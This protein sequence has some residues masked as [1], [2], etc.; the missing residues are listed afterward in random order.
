MRGKRVILL[1]AGRG[2]RWDNYLGIPKH[3]IEIDSGDGRAERLIDRTVRLVRERSDEATTILIASFDPRYEVPGTMRYEPAHGRERFTDTDKFLSSAELWS[4]DDP[5]IVL[6]GDVFFTEAAMETIL[7]FAGA[8]FAFFGRPRPS[9]CTGHL[10][11]EMFALVIPPGSREHLQRTMLEVRDMLDEGQIRRG[12]GWECYRHACG[13]TPVCVYAVRSDVANHFVEI[14]DFTDDFDS[15]YDYEQ[16]L[17]RYELYKQW[18]A[19]DGVNGSWFVGLTPRLLD[20]E[21]PV[22]THILKR[23]LIQNHHD[24]A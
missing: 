22:S 14:D 6:Y 17:W 1:C 7:S 12:G 19:G 10:W 20:S 5:T 11:Q 2:E 16:W 18:R 9:Q 3:L 15:P 4:A 23:F 13:L 24:R 21:L 8:E